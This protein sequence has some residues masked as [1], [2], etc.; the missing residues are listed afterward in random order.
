MVRSSLN[1]ATQ[2]LYPLIQINRRLSSHVNAMCHRRALV[3]LPNISFQYTR[4][5]HAVAGDTWIENVTLNFFFSSTTLR[6]PRSDER[7]WYEYACGGKCIEIMIQPISTKWIE[8]WFFFAKNE[9]HTLIPHLRVN[10]TLSTDF[11]MVTGM[12][13]KKS[14]ARW[15]CS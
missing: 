13:R 7:P 10:T 5:L 11:S 1:V 6:S 2:T 14:L 8:V 15:N 12:T 3:H 9:K 4:S